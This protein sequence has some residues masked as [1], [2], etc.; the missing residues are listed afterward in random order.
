MRTGSLN[1]QATSFQRYGL[2]AQALHWFAALLLF[3]L[4][5]T[6]AMREIVSNPEWAGAFLRLHMSLGILIFLV[7]IA[8]LGWRKVSPPP[9]LVDAP[10]WSQA[11]ANIS[12]ILLNLATLLIPISGYLRIASAGYPANFFGIEIPSIMGE[13]PWL[14]QLTESVTHGDPMKL[15]ILAL[16]GL[17][18]LAAL[19]HQYVWKD[20][21]MHRMLPW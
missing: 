6:N 4:L 9:P 3:G 19:W 2:V 7:T 13:T 16:V 21:V 1:D 12:H 8:R 5:A 18:I 10:K 15:F 20:N 14:H 17:H 11:A